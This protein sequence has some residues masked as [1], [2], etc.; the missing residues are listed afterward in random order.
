MLLAEQYT[1]NQEFAIFFVFLL[2]HLVNH[3]QA[4]LLCLLFK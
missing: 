3:L 4:L 2:G 1:Y